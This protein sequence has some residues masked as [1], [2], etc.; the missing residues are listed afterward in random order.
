MSSPE[1]PAPA[2]TGPR[3]FTFRGVVKG[4]EPEEGIVSI[5]HED[6]PGLM[7]A[8][9]MDFKP[10]D[11]SLLED[12]LAGDEVEGRLE[13]SYDSEGKLSGLDLVGLVVTRP[14]VA[15]PPPPLPPAVARLEPGQPV[16]DFSMN[17][18][19]GQR[20]TLSELRGKIVVLTF[21]YTRCPLPDFCPLMDRRFAELAEMSGRTME[22]AGRVRLLSVS[23]DPEHDTPE[24][25]AR[26][27]LRTGG[28]PPLWT[29]AVASHEELRKVAEPLGLQ[30]APTGR[31]IRHG[32]STSVI[33]PDGTLVRLENNNTWTAA[34]L[35]STVR[36]LLRE[37]VD[38]PANS[39]GPSNHQ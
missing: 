23:F 26:H 3:E 9:L 29:Y 7:P 22:R 10:E 39:G 36:E 15:E 5:D 28:R 11:R 17:T 30:Y 33:G 6:I 2:V 13:A 12:V 20:L 19:D 18:Q 25:L 37:S 16:P 35:F 32:L 27:A 38:E 21:V 34:S 4:V 24:V 14:A 31:E 1:K 8:M